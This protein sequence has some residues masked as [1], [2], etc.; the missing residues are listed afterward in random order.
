MPL[1]LVVSLCWFSAL[2]NK[3]SRF[4]NISRSIGTSGFV[5]SAFCHHPCWHQFAGDLDLHAGEPADAAFLAKEYGIAWAIFATEELSKP[6]V[7]QYMEFCSG[8]IPHRLLTTD[9]SYLP[10]IWNRSHD[11]RRQRRHPHARTIVATCA[12]LFETDTDLLVV[13][14]LGFILSPVILALCLWVKFSSPGPIFYGQTRLGR[15]GKKFKAWKF[16]SMIV[17]AD[18]VLKDYLVKHPELKAEYE[19]TFKLQNDR[20]SLRLGISSASR[21]WM[22]CRNCGMCSKAK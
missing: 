22:N 4:A 2:V 3:P 19:A 20:A 14:S 16:R 18:A 15:N 21:A 5:L 1:E 10:S 17:N 6:E 13:C 8:T 9:L 12:A 11:S 7:A